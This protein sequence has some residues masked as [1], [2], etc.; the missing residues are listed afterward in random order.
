MLMLY[1]LYRSKQKA[2]AEKMV[3]LQREHEI[4][5]LTAMM[6]G[7]EKERT[8]LARELHDG[9]GGIL[10]ATKMHLSVLRQ[11]QSR[12]ESSSKFDHTVSMLESASQEIRS[13]SHNLWPDILQHYELDA[14]LARFCKSVSN[15]ALQ[16]DFYNLG[17]PPRLKSSYKLIIYRM[18]QELVNNIIKHAEASNAL[19]QLSHH[20]HLLSVTVEDN[21][22]GFVQKEI[23]GI[24]LLKLQARVRNINGQMNI[25]TSP[26]SGTTVYLE[27][28]AT[29][30]METPVCLSAAV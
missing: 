16:V 25:E 4:K 8:R 23:T 11:E 9:V 17:D 15:A 21:G 24:G 22:A 1:L 2:A 28:D 13:I 5:V 27:F 14:A 30:F 12:P 18:V 10:S 20:D 3:A 19:V 6:E 7:E 29:T 26:G